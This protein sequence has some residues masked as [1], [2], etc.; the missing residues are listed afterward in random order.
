MPAR[1]V[2]QFQSRSARGHADDV[3]GLKQSRVVLGRY[4]HDGAPGAR[5]VGSVEVRRGQHSDRL[6]EESPLEHGHALEGFGKGNHV[7]ELNGGWHGGGPTLATMESPTLAASP[8]GAADRFP[9]ADVAPA[10][11]RP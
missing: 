6:L 11:A 7:V 3:G 4:P 2:A 5:P 1:D 8:W 10:S 9:A